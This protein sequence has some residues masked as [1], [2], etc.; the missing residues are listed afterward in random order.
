M[1]HWTDKRIAGH[2]CMCY[3]AY[4]LLNYTLLKLNQNNNDFSEHSLRKILDRMQLSLIEQ[5]GKEIFLRSA[6]GENEVLLQKRLGLKIIPNIF[7]KERKS[8]Y[9]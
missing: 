3:I 5:D 8:Q 6:Q 9:A 1:F 4:T 2:I 7:P